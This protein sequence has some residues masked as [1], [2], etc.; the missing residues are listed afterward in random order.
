MVGG[1]FGRL[2]LAGSSETLI[3]QFVTTEGELSGPKMALP[4]DIT[5]E[6]LHTLLN[7]HILKNVKNGDYILNIP[8]G[9][10]SLL[11][12]CTRRGG[13]VKFTRSYRET[14]D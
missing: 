14:R 13:C 3:A 7:D 8:G 9:H 5:L 12:L 4:K 11:I 6:Q 2:T 10:S 1:Q